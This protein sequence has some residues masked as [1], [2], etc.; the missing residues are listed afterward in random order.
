MADGRRPLARARHGPA[1]RGRRRIRGEDAL[2]RPAGGARGSA[3][4]RRRPPRP[5][6]RSRDRRAAAR[7][8]GRAPRRPRRGRR[9][10]AAR[11]TLA[12]PGGADARVRR[13]GRGG[14]ER[15]HRLGSRAGARLQ[16]AAGGAPAGP[17]RPFLQ[18]GRRLGRRR[19][20][21]PRAVGGAGRLPR[22]P[23]G[24]TSRAARRR[25]A[26]RAGRRARSRGRH[27][28]AL[29][30]RGRRARRAR[31]GRRAAP[32]PAGGRALCARAPAHLH[33]RR[34]GTRQDGA[35]AGHA[36]GRRGVPGAGGLPGEHEADLGARELD[37]AAG[38]QRRADRRAG[39][40]R[41]HAGGGGRRDRR[42]QL[43]HPR[44]PPG[45][46]GRARAAGAGA[47]RVA[48]RQEPGGRPDQG[49]DP[50]VGGPAR[51]RPAPG[52]HGHARARTG[53]R[54]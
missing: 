32:V 23:P 3:D 37:L 49:G 34:A 8:R 31:A 19:A 44:R 36:R 30:R 50:P 7:A 21:R 17:T 9:T 1:P 47:R 40:I 25:V 29:L 24:C 28:R 41:V 11:G 48:L 13:R 22:R 54:S 45:T 15:G 4:R 33:R 38:A 5:A 20:R 43:R 18:P 39:G 42:A 51:R 27:R 10:R 12:G 6:V 35:G 52:S 14:A 53:P 46:P 16:A 26:G 2:R